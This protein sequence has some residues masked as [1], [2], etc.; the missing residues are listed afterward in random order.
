[1]PIP[2]TT[3]RR[4]I[5]LACHAPSAHNTQPWLWRIAGDQILLYADSRRQLPAEDPD[6]RNL[7]ISCGAALHHLQFAARALGWASDVT[8]VP[9]PDEPDLL[10]SVRLERCEPSLQPVNDLAALRRRC[11]DRRRF[12]SW[13]VPPEVLDRLTEEAREL[14]VRATP[15]VDL[16]ARFRLELLTSDAS[17]LRE[18]DEDAVREQALWVNRAGAEGVPLAVLPE[19]EHA[20][21]LDRPGR[22]GPGLVPE[23]RE[24]VDSGDGVIVLGGSTDDPTGWLRTGQG[25]SALWLRATRDGLS[26]VPLSLPVEVESTRIQ[27]T[28]TVLE[29]AFVPHLAVRIGWQ[30]IGRTG[31]PRTPRRGLDDVL[32]R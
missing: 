11:T 22:F 3:A 14:D 2:M 13:P 27:M 24:P 21:V 10:A 32:I 23:T 29:G 9:R 1:M 28:E 20:D 8:L 15:V 12:T 19:D 5:E 30:A 7:T 25:L 18:L 16:V 4:L 26:V 31:L 17:A 6:G